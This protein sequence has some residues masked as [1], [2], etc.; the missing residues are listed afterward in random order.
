MHTDN[1][2]DLI[3]R[4]RRQ[5]ARFRSRSPRPGADGGRPAPPDHALAGM[6][7]NYE[8]VREL[9]RGGQGVVYLARQK[10]TRRAVAVKV[11]REGPFAS[12]AVQHRFQ[13]EVEVLAGLRHPNIVT[14]HDSGSAAGFSYYVMTYVDGREID[15]YA[16]DL[17]C[18][19]RL[20]V[21][22]K[23]CE[24][25]HAAHLRGV[26]HRDL[27]PGNIL[28]DP[29]G[30]PQVLD[31]GLAKL[32]TPGEDSLVV[33]Q[34]G[35]FLGS[36]PWAS[37]E[38]VD[39]RAA[40]MDL[41]SDVYSLGVVLYQMVTG[42]FPYGVSGPIR[43]VM[44]QILTAE[45]VRPASLPAGCDADLETI[46]L[47]CLEKTPDRRYQSAADVAADLRRYLA[48]EPIDAKR[49]HTLYLLRR[50][51][52]RHR[53][54]V[55][56]GLGAFLLAVGSAVAFSMMYRQQKALREEAE[57]QSAIARAE[58]DRAEKFAED[59]RSKFRLVSDT[60]A[61][62]LD[63]VSTRLPGLLGA[64]PLRN[65]ILQKTY[66]RFDALAGEQADDPSLR[67]KLAQT[68]R[69]LGM[70]ANDLGRTGEVERHARAAKR[71]FQ[72][73]L[74]TEPGQTDA[75]VGLSG[76]CTLIADAAAKRGDDAVAEAEYE[77][78]IAASKRALELRP[79]DP[80][81]MNRYSN[82]CGLISRQRRRRGD[83]RQ[84]AVWLDRACEV[85]QAL[86]SRFPENVKYQR[87]LGLCEYYRA[88]AEL[89]AGRTA[90]AEARFHRTIEIHQALLAK[91]PTQTGVLENLGLCYSALCRN[92]ES[93][94]RLEEGLAW[95]KKSGDAYQRRVQAEPGN[96]N[97]Q[98]FHAYACSRVG[99]LTRRLD[100]PQVA[101]EAYREALAGY[102]RIISAEPRNHEYRIG[103]AGVLVDLGRIAAEG[104]RHE[105]AA[106][107]LGEAI[108]LHEAVLRDGM[109]I[110]QEE[111][112]P[113]G[114][115][116]EMAELRRSMG[117]GAEARRHY[118]R[119][120]EISRAVM[121]QRPDPARRATRSTLLADTYAS[122][123]RVAG[124]MGDAPAAEEAEQEAAAWR[125][126]ARST[127]PD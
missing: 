32:D 47:K 26:I 117:A 92:C 45:P 102:R 27:K 7:P 97:Y 22:I 89:A 21:F 13:R 119:A 5:A 44:E 68:R 67:L 1:E 124:E 88:E 84:A 40:D 86:A 100:R 125:A 60:A 108:D 123:A 57:R 61:F 17:P 96:A 98:Y 120:I 54:P 12:P 35:Q 52:R 78:A 118:L 127:V 34:T 42:Q 72:E 113:A 105:E 62:M 93:A 11:M 64:G 77:Q 81:V 48:G 50:T 99:A 51:I 114:V 85:K 82:V 83:E 87:E 53:L 28:I 59:S 90:E 38:Q 76:S 29:A 80:E 115:H 91:E 3:E 94:G 109:K 39:G 9:H 41:R 104:G 49:D 101:E 74:S 46:V 37:P 121:E 69:Q 126:K 14:I 63:L 56:A 79:D 25:V 122:L 111:D 112:T 4:A 30:E 15:A 110:Y 103:G 58:R 36:L 95:A 106:A 43:T 70:L 31:F 66:E 71:Q 6:L 24:A 116:R 10:S 18:R 2:N 55:A 19:E 16:R 107:L 73:V 20:P 33:T 23:A 75:L 8:M 65:E